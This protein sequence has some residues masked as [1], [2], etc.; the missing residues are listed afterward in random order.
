MIT[1]ISCAL[2]CTCGIETTYYNVTDY[3]IYTSILYD[4]WPS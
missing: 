3:N 1:S 4:K 2:F